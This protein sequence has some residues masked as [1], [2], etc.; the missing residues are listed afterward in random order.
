MAHRALRRGLARPS[1]QPAQV[2]EALHRRADHN[3]IRGDDGAL[4]C[5]VAIHEDITARLAS[6]EKVAYI[7]L[8]DSLTDLGNR[9]ALDDRLDIELNR[10]RRLGSCVAALWI[11]LDNFKDVN[12]TFGHS[13]GDALLIAVGKRLSSALRDVDLICRLGGDEFAVVAPDIDG[14]KA[15]ANLAERLLATFQKPFT[16]EAQEIFSSA[17]IGVTITSVNPIS[18]ADFMKQAD[19]ALYRTKSEGR[20]GYRFFET[21]MDVE[22]RRRMRLAQD[23]HRAVERGEL[24]LEYQPQV[25]LGDRRI[26]G[27]EALVRWQHPQLG[28]I[29]P[30]EFIP[31]AESSGLIEQVGAWVLRAACTQARAW[32]DR[33]LPPFPIAV[34][35]SAIQLRDPRFADSIA[36]LL[37]ELGLAPEFLDLE[38]TERVLMDANPLTERTLEALNGMGVGISLD[39]FGKGY[40][41]LDYL[42]RYPLSKVK[43]DQSFVHDM[44]TN[45]KNATI[46]SA[47]IDLASK[48]GLRVIAEGVEP[49]ALLERLVAEGCEQ[50]QGFYFSKPRSADGLER[51]FTTGNDRIRAH[52]PD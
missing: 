16:V 5:F 47:V 43:I 21:E 22:I 38:L 48:L 6:E 33:G 14:R 24:F 41:S 50:V 31:V 42:R 36:E 15:A 39:D 23:L 35:I 28:V 10:A 44:E 26:V 46:V 30:T 51:L 9:Y 34:N 40:A 7:A 17:S 4:E 2:R 25:A 11:D 52:P 37:A 13:V 32:Q 45:F 12:D 19:L 49:Q 3:L 1:R 18:R 27:V 29:P 8:H 20:N